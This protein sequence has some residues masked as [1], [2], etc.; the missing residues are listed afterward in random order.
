MVT[1]TQEDLIELLIRQARSAELWLGFWEKH[2]DPSSMKNAAFAIGKVNG[3][4]NAL[5]YLVTGDEKLP[6]QVTELGRKYNEIWENLY[7]PEKV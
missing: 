2:K 1:I 5:V 3:I 6:E 4:Y 7:L